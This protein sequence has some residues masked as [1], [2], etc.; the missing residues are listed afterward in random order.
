VSKIIFY[1]HFH[2]AH[3]RNARIRKKYQVKLKLKEAAL[4]EL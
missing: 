3:V 1:K 4:L 2:E